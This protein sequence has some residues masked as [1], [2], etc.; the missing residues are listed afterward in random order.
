MAD[1][2][3]GNGK[4]P[5]PPVVPDGAE[6]VGRGRDADQWLQPLEWL[7]FPVLWQLDKLIM[8]MADAMRMKA[9]RFI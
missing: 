2:E 8:A 1:G 6:D 3:T 4:A 9:R 5:A 7:W